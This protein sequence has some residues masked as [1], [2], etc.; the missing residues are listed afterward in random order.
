M[1]QKVLQ[2]QAFK[3]EI[4][5]VENN[6]IASYVSLGGNPSTPIEFV[7]TLVNHNHVCNFPLV[8]ISVRFVGWF[9]MI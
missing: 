3:L 8:V 5:L 4:D 7:W 6:S 1:T 9:S 2:N